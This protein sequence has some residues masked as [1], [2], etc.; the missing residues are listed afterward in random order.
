MRIR[1]IKDRGNI[2]ASRVCEKTSS[3]Q[4]L[5]STQGLNTRVIPLLSVGRNTQ[6]SIGGNRGSLGLDHWDI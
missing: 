6:P 1:S 5:N 3:Y 2:G 4:L